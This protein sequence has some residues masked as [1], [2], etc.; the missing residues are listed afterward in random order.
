M[1]TFLLYR[2]TLVVHLVAVISWMAGILYLIRLFVY[3]SQE[4]EEVVKERFKTMEKKLYLYITIPAMLVAFFAGVT[5]LLLNPA[6][7]KQHWMH[8]KLLLVFIMMGVTHSCGPMM[9]KLSKD[10]KRYSNKFLRY[11]NELPTI[12][13]IGIVIAVIIRPW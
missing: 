4:H 8:L 10:S 5:L 2:W 7:I 9:R 1:E 11:Y 6:L 13:M 12:L 3:H